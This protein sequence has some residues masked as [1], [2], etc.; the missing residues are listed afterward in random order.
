MI[1]A[2]KQVGQVS[3]NRCQPNSNRLGEL[4][5]TLTPELCRQDR[6]S[7]RVL[8]ATPSKRNPTRGTW[9]AQ[10]PVD[11]VDDETGRDG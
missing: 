9:H 4:L 1:Q 2:P 10:S 5:H 11:A 3:P 8:P 7:T 6:R